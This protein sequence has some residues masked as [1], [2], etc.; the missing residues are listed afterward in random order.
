[1][2]HVYKYVLK[3]PLR[4][5]VHDRLN[6]DQQLPYFYTDNLSRYQSSGIFRSGQ[7]YNVAFLNQDMVHKI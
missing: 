4:Q 6:V 3:H 5:N 7:F 2:W 1:M